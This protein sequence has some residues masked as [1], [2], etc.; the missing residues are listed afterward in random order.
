MLVQTMRSLH[1]ALTRLS[2]NKSL[3]LIALMM[4]IG[5]SSPSWANE[6]SKTAS[7]KAAIDKSLN[8]SPQMSP[9]K[10]RRSSRL[11]FKDGPVCLCAD[12]LQE[13]DILN[14]RKPKTSSDK[15]ASQ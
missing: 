12:G 6:T 15:K 3:H 11:R 5:L 7:S 2:I 8:Q 4:C 13:E 14:A 9:V 1:Q 10:E